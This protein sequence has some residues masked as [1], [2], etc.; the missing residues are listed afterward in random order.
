MKKKIMIPIVA[1]AA[2]IT[3][4]ILLSSYFVY[5]AAASS[6]EKQQYIYS[7]TI[8]SAEDLVIN[9][10]TCDIIIG[11]NNTPMTNKID[12]HLGYEQMIGI[13]QVAYQT[14]EQSTILIPEKT[15]ILK[16]TLRTDL[17][18]NL[19]ALTVNG[20]ISFQVPKHVSVG[21]VKLSTVAGNI[22]ASFNQNSTI[23]DLAIFCTTGTIKLDL[24]GGNIN[25]DIK[26]C[27]INGLTSVSLI[28][29][30]YE[31][32][33]KID[34]YG[35][36]GNILLDIDQNIEMDANIEGTIVLFTGNILAEYSDSV[37]NVSASFSCYS[38]TGVANQ[39]TSPDHPA[40]YSYYFSC[41]VITGNIFVSG[42]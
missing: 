30:S 38:G 42:I 18:Y 40:E 17:K 41:T 34:I 10:K 7:E 21:S 23:E 28:N 3:T 11:Y 5:S 37:N 6:E 32:D 29:P 39:Y 2:L 26:L 14:Q 15:E 8:G 20:S 25:G 13:P 33:C 12:V 36:T 1:I 22:L 27:N 9:V 31:E 4:G 16:V 24:N 35:I 19:N